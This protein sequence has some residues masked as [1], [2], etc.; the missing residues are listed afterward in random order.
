M[1]HGTEIDIAIIAFAL[2][3]GLQGFRRGFVVGACS[4]VGLTVG[5]FLGTRIGPLLLSEGSNSQ[6]APIFGMAGALIGAI[7]LAFG[8][9]GMGLALRRRLRA[10]GVSTALDGVLG[11][12]LAAGVGLAMVWI[13]AA[14]ILYAPVA[15]EYRSDV[16]SSAI[17]KRMMTAF[18]PSGPVLNA[19]ASLDPLPQLE[20]PSTHLQAPKTAVARDPEVKGASASVVK[21]KGSACG[22]G[23]EGSGWVV[24]PHTVVTNAHVV[25]GESDTS[26]Q[27]GGEGPEYE[28][29]VVFF[30]S[31]NDIAI[32]RVP[33][34][35]LPALELRDGSGNGVSAAI[36]GYPLDGP[37]DVRAA[38]IGTT[39]TALT[40]DIYGEGQYS[41]RIVSFAGNVRQGNSGGP[42]VDGD[43]R[44]V[45]TVFAAAV[46]GSQR[47]G[48]GIPNSLITEAL[49]QAGRRAVQTGRCA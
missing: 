2:A 38:R 43:G 29:T 10:H 33:E 28:A 4:L 22:L 47:A 8:L 42:V 16:R 25:A 32:L 14:G 40:D 5:A 37:Y 7:V 30:D 26:V 49:Q 12:V 18:P 41:R 48:Y 19:L 24:A 3:L 9:E 21:V 36:L 20:G 34:L 6:Y 45:A 35:Q 1:S 31:R 15:R 46:G 23:L 13:A 27:P 39:T 11:G 17:I 44:V